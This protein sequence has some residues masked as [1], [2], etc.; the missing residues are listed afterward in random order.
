MKPASNPERFKKLSHRKEDECHLFTWF[1]PGG[2][3]F[4]NDYAMSRGRGVPSD[5]PPCPDFLTHLWLTAVYSPAL[6]GWHRDSG[7]RWYEVYD[8]E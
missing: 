3:S 5:P 8:R 1:G 7:W 4:A 6:L 2:L